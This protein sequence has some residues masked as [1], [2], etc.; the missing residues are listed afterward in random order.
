M[1]VL[2]MLRMN[3]DP[4]LNEFV[5]DINDVFNKLFRIKL[6]KAVG[7]DC[8]PNKVLKQMAHILAPPFTAIINCSLRLGVIVPDSW[9]LSR[10]TPPPKTVPVHSIESDVHPIAVT[11]SVAKI[12]ESFVCKF[13]SFTFNVNIDSNLCKEDPPLKHYC[14][15]CTCYFKH[16]NFQITLSEFDL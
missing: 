7:P 16:L 14:R 15:L 6:N 9:K 5:V 2:N 1:T 3:L 11:N 8:I 12:A 10:I 4:V 13:F